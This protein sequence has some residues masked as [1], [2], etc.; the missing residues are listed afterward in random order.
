[1]DKRGDIAFDG[2]MPPI[3]FEV[4]LTPCIFI[5]KELME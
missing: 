2:I 1:M 5:Y 4:C 3:R